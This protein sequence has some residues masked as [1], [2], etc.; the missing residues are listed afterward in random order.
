MKAAIMEVSSHALCQKR[1][2]FIDFDVA[3][4]TNLSQDH[5]DYH[6]NMQNYAEAKGLLFQKLKAT[7]TAVVNIDD[8]RASFMIKKCKANII[9]FAIDNKADLVANNIQLTG[10]GMEFD[11]TYLGKVHS[12]KTALTGRFNVYNVLAAISAALVGRV[13]ISAVEEALSSFQ[14]VPGRLQRLSI[15]KPYSVFIDF[16]HTEDALENVLK[17]LS[18]FKLSKIITVFGCGGDRD[19]GKR[20]KMGQVASKYS[21]SCIITSDNSRFEDPERIILEILKG[22]DGGKSFPILDRREAIKKAFELANKNDIVLIA[23]RGHEEHL[24]I[25]GQMIPFNDLQVALELCQD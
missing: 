2:D 1:A 13:P 21:D 11:L 17:T 12:I 8:P 6:E 10:E 23:G 4:F 16:A 19:K 22:V 25:R 18:E 14:A 9:T 15:N 7:A 20:S 3:I 5:L 24:K